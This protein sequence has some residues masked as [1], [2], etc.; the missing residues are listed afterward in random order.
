LLSEPTAP[1]DP[2]AT[3]AAAT[4]AAPVPAAAPQPKPVVAAAS[5]SP[6]AAPK[7]APAAQPAPAQ[8]KADAPRPPAGPYF[9][10][11]KGEA[12]GP[13]SFEQ[14]R[15][16]ATAGELA[17]VDLIWSDTAKQ[18]VAASTVPDLFP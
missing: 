16:L 8:P 17:P 3:P 4:P 5:A 18:W 2:F 15:Q 12:R 9:D 13:V 10:S 14:L 1:I 11:R 6:A 7:A